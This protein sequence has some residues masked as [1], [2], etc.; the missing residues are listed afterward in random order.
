LGGAR[1]LRVLDS[2]G[3]GV[4]PA[5]AAAPAK[6]S[7][8]QTLVFRAR[9]PFDEA[10]LRRLV[11]Q[12]HAGVVRAKGFFWVA[13]RPDDMGYLSLAGGVARWE[14]AGTWAAA[15]L[16][17]GVITPAELP[18]HAHEHWQEP[19]GDRRQELVFIGMDFEPAVL[20]GDLEACQVPLR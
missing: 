11:E 15:L 5:G 2:H 7:Q 8:W 1:W 17:R 13:G 12:H 4:R 19:H 9:E 16:A 18:A 20:Q 3:A 10:K 6:A 14:W